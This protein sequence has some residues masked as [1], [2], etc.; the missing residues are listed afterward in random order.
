MPSRSIDF[1]CFFPSFQE[2]DALCRQS[3]NPMKCNAMTIKTGHRIT[4]YEWAA[5]VIAM[6]F[7]ML[8]ERRTRSQS[9]SREW[10]YDDSLRFLA[11]ILSVENFSFLFN[12]WMAAQKKPHRF[13]PLWRL[14]PIDCASLFPFFVL[15]LFHHFD[16]AFIRNYL[17][18]RMLNSCT[19]LFT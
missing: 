15:F 5:K 18:K 8:T 10:I 12:S 6:Q 3:Y 14:K 7:F 2:V 9:V 13:G 19:P 17:T 1:F 16:V 11:C 4:K